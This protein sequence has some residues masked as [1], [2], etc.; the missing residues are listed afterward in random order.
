MR[1]VNQRKDVV[2][3]FFGLINRRRF[4]EET[5]LNINDQQGYVAG[6]PG[7]ILIAA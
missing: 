2:E 6:I 4:P 3:Q 1:A 5:V 7:F